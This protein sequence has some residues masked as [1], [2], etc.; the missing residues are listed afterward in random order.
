MPSIERDSV[1]SYLVRHLVGPLKG[2]FEEVVGPPASRYTCGILFPT[3]DN[4]LTFESSANGSSFDD[5]GDSL[6]TDSGDDPVKLSGQILPCSLGLSFYT[7]S[8]SL[9]CVVNAAIY[10]L[11]GVDNWKRRPMSETVKIDKAVTTVPILSG[12]AILKLKWRNLPVGGWLITLTILNSSTL[13]KEPT[14]FNCPAECLYQVSVKCICDEGIGG[15]PSSEHIGQLTAEEEDLELLYRNSKPYA[16]GH[17]CA[18]SNSLIQQDGTVSWVQSEII[19]QHEVPPIVPSQGNDEVLKIKNLVKLSEVVFNDLSKFLDMYEDWISQNELIAGNLARRYQSASARLNLRQRVALGRMRRGVELISSD[20]KIQDSFKLANEA[21]LMQMFHT[22]EFAKRREFDGATR[23]MPNESDYMNFKAEWRPFQLAFFLLCIGSEDGTNEKPGPVD[24]IWFP[25]GGGKT[26]AYLAVAAFKIFHRRLAEPVRGGG[27]AVITRYT[28]RLLTAQQFQRAS[29]L[30]CAMEVLRRRER[31]SL[32]NSIISLGLWIG[33]KATPNTF[34]EAKRIFEEIV[35]PAERPQNPFQLQMCPWCGTSIIPGKK[36]LD[37]HAYGVIVRNDSFKLV[38][39]NSNCE[40]GG[41]DQTLPIN[42]VDDA[43]YSDPPTVLIGTVDKFA[44]LPWDEKAGCFFGSENSDPPTLIIQDEMHLLAGPLGTIV[45][46]YEAAIESLCRVKS[47]TGRLPSIIASTAT[48]RESDSQSKHLYGRDVSVFPPSGLTAGDSFFA[49]EDLDRP[50]RLYVG[51]LGSIH[52]KSTSLIR[53]AAVLAQAPIEVELSE[54][55]RDAYWTQVIYHNSLRELGQT[56]TF[57]RD[58]IPTWIMQIAIDQDITRRLDDTNVLEITSNVNSSDIPAALERL[59]E[60][61]EGDEEVS[62]LVCTNMF[63]VGVDVQ[64]L[65]LILMNSQ[66]KSTAEYIQSTS[67]VGRAED[68][69]RPGLVVCHYATNKPR[70]RSHYEHFAAYHA[71]L[72]RYVEPS[73][74]SPTAVRARERVLHA[75]LVI[76]ARHGVGLSSN[77]DAAKFTRSDEDMAKGIQIL[78]ERYARSDESEIGAISDEINRIASDWEEKTKLNLQYQTQNKVPAQTHPLLKYYGQ[79]GE[80][81]ATL[82]N[83]R[84][85]DDEC[86]IRIEI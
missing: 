23:V 73:S 16:I 7:R 74:V 46:A 11:V 27:T 3:I 4:G 57:A 18:T 65:G 48:I 59:N 14:A 75:A 72:Y 21:M 86:E 47:P 40:F 45:G 51:V 2:E 70:D 31:V 56:T 24:L 42:V 19:P 39:P 55:I 44:R 60:S 9:T 37:R 17:G 76:M 20:Q 80:G 8:N 71:A 84:N 38:C 67:R 81:W 28:L 35:L 13:K 53:T 33:K 26:E 50:G 36:Y 6:P 78:I 43:L 83:M 41:D 15:Y 69:S 66:P 58:D 77:N 85:V 62:L 61:H 64:R 82:N 54:S 68:G 1:V 29:A 22:R 79:P 25:T 5:F 32:G 52:S 34:S 12:R 63:S 49:S 30:V 10:E